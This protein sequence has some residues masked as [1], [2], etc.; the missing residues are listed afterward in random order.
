MT[1]LSYGTLE[2]NERI[3]NI[4]EECSMLV[5][6]CV[7]FVFLITVCLLQHSYVF[8]AYLFQTNHKVLAKGFP[9]P[10]DKKI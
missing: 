8:I 1:I 4:I 3:R 5:C 6:E 9:P 7:S 2:L 10:N